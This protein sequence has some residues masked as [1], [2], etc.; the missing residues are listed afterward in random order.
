MKRAWR[1]LAI[2][3]TVYLLFLASN[4]PAER[5]R[6][7][8][9][10]R[11]SD[12]TLLAVT[13]SVF[14]GQAR[15]LVFQGMDLGAL[16]WQFRPAALLL[17]RAEFRVELEHPYNHGR[18]NIG[19]TLLGHAYGQELDLM[20]RP[21]RVINHYSPVAVSTSG[22]LHLEID[23]LD[24]DSDFPMELAGRLTWQDAAVLEPVDMVLGDI[25]LALQGS[26]EELAG[27]VTRGGVL[28]ASGD[29]A[30]LPERRYRVNLVLRPGNDASTA[31]LD[32]LEKY[33]RMQA[34]GDYL[35]DVSGQ[36]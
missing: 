11:V 10:S 24:L 19:I 13:G 33:T 14:S 6:T 16:H 9:E 3:I 28:G 23:T 35:I 25:E 34:N 36:L 32:L 29:L 27:S 12:L 26:P 7:L 8:L 31:T 15:Q 1:Y 4:F 30:L 5:L 22:E 2:G 20:L 21:D 18:G 17:G